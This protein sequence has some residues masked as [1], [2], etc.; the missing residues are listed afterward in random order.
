MI[1]QALKQLY[2]ILKPG[3]IAVIEVPA[4][5]VLYD[6]MMTIKTLPEI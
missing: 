4:N 2:R 3:G 1:K 5:P 6:F